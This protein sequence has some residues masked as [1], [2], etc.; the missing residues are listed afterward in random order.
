M[1]LEF[2]GGLDAVARHNSPWQS[3]VNPHGNC[4]VT[5]QV[6]EAGRRCRLGLSFFEA[7]K[8]VE[9]S[10]DPAAW[11]AALRTAAHQAGE[12]PDRWAAAAATG[13]DRFSVGQGWWDARRTGEPEHIALAAAWPLLRSSEFEPDDPTSLPRWAARWCEGPDV[14]NAATRVLGGRT[15][16]R[17]TRLIGQK[18]TGRPEWWPLALVLATPRLDTGQVGDVLS[19]LD[20]EYR[21]DDAQFALLAGTLG[22]AR[23]DHAVQL[24]QSAARDGSPQRLLDG[25]DGLSRADHVIPRLPTTIS[26]LEEVVAD[27]LLPQ[28]PPN[29]PQPHPALRRRPATVV[30]PRPDL[31]DHPASWA[32]YDGARVGDIELVLPNSPA[33]LE[34]WGSELRNC[35]GSYTALVDSGRRLVLGIQIRGRLAGAVEV[36]PARRSIIQLEAANNRPMPRTTRQAVTA[37]LLARGAIARA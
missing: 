3:M 15:S 17:V 6:D 18:L 25:L 20:N 13:L 33:E 23:P 31:F 10:R 32:Q 5:I 27:A 35:L 34:L 7:A 19:G 16:R 14:R 8:V 26:A 37:M 22:P 4:P 30:D 21:C 29:R 24:L 2:G 9:V 36:D 11:F 1:L 28:P 12:H